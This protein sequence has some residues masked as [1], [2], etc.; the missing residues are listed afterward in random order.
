[1]DMLLH[2]NEDFDDDLLQDAIEL[3]VGWSLILFPWK[4]LH[5]YLFFIYAKYNTSVIQRDQSY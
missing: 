3:I 5:F 4:Y 2:I 1:M